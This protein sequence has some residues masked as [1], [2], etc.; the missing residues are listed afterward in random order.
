MKIGDKVRFLSEEG[1][2]FIA[3]F[4]KGNIV[5]VEDEDGF[6]I[7][8]LASQVVVI[9]DGA[10][11]YN[12]FKV[13]SAGQKGGNSSSQG[14]SVRSMINAGSEDN[15]DIYSDINS[16]LYKGKAAEIDDDP[17]LGEIT[18]Q[19]P[20]TERKGGDRLSAYLAFV[21][22][23][24]TVITGTRFYI[25]LVNDCNYYLHY[26]LLQAEGAAWT[27]RSTG[28]LEPNTK[29]YIDEI[30]REDL[31]T[32]EHLGIQMI[33][34]KREKS[35]TIKP[36][37]DVQLRIDGVKFYKLHTFQSNKFF[38]QDALVYTIIENDTPARPLVVDAKQLKK[39][40]YADAPRPVQKKIT[41]RKEDDGAVIVDMH[42]DALLD[43]TQGMSSAD[44]LQHQ[45]D[46][47]HRTIAEYK[48]KQGTRLI[49]IHGKGDGVLRRSII[50]SLNYRYKFLR[51]QDASF[52]EY[53]YGAT[54]VTI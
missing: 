39:D 24:P 21:P 51:Y 33:P 7:P 11:D 29:T 19:A 20:A 22:V 42:I 44:I 53:G 47:F 32:L 14:K 12:M 50:N 9:A 28:E 15:E 23:D 49:F 52:Q 31:E 4:Q 10:D 2:G 45:M 1:G 48:K 18:F 6:Q 37:I 13:P 3:G 25:Y 17:S 36:T 16:P 35:F 41:A 40:M 26:T 43:S 46:V 30:G 8:T 5:L 38:E 27:L 34:Y 54:Q